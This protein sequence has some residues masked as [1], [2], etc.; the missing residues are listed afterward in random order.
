MDVSGRSGNQRQTGSGAESFHRQTQLC[1]WQMGGGYVGASKHVLAFSCLKSVTFSRDCKGNKLEPP[2]Q[3][4]T[5]CYDR[6][7]HGAMMMFR[8]DGPGGRAGKQQKWPEVNY[9]GPR[10]KFHGR[11]ARAVVVHRDASPASTESLA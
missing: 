6:G 4:L 3:Q 11:S 1:A 2:V 9:T 5:A 7:G 10:K 8:L